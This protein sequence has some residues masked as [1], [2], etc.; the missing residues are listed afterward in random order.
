MLILI[1]SYKRTEILPLVLKSVLQCDVSGIDERKLVLIANNYPPNREIV[2]SIINECEFSNDIECKAIHRETTIPAVDSWFSAMAEYATEGE[3]VFLL[4]DDDLLL[5]WGLRDRYSEI[6][7]HNADM[8]L[9]DFAG[10]I[11]FFEK[12]Q[13]Y[14]LCGS[15]PGEAQQEKIARP[16][17]F[18]PAKHPEASFMSNHCYRNTANF[19]K[20]LALAF[21][22][23]DSQS[24]LERSVRTSM[25]PFYIPY[26]IAVSDGKVISLQ[27]KCVLRGAIAAEALRSTYS[28]GGNLSFYHLLAYCI[29]TNIELPH[30]SQRLA[31]VAARFKPGFLSGFFTILIDRNV[32]LKELLI[33]FYKS[34]LRLRDLFCSSVAG[35]IGVVLTNMFGLRGLNL[36]LR[37]RSKSLLPT[38]QFFSKL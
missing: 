10:R 30:Y 11:F 18:F 15:I 31:G 34:N 8:L 14:W 20:G 12:G 22:W 29:F 26:A 19:R 6:L 21:G 4:G 3:V 36:R 28:D 27:S 35:S 23:C 9:S 24:W 25:L 37:A 16:W 5:P 13:K 32:Q 17:E 7:K 33:T 38:S 2:N 1:P